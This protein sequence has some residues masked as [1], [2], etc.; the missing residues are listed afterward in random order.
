MTPPSA[1]VERAAVLR[2]DVY[3]GSVHCAGDR[4]A[5]GAP[6]PQLTKEV[7]VG[8]PIR[9]EVPAGHHAL[10]L[11]AFADGAATELLGS[12]CIEA[13]LAADTTPCFNLTLQAAPDLGTC[14]DTA[15]AISNCGACGRACSSTKVAA[16]ACVAGLCAPS[17]DPGYGDCNR[18]IAPAAD[19]GCETSLNDVNHC[20][21][22]DKVCQIP[23][24]ISSCPN[25]SCLLKSCAP[26]FFDCNGNAEDG[27]E[28][29]GTNLG[30]GNKGCCRG[31][32]QVQHANGIGSSF[33]DC[34]P[35]GAYSLQLA[36]DAAGPYYPNG[37]TVTTPLITCADGKTLMYCKRGAVGSV[38][39]ECA[40]WTYGCIG[41][42]GVC[43][44][45]GYANKISGPTDCTCPTI[46]D[47]P[48]Q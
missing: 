35:L 15:S 23:N 48:Y 16:P 5:P 10:V 24:A 43:P 17:C 4:I 8:Q 20:G 22:C 11:S 39:T 3:D 6:P 14:G 25:G 42:A 27:C 45:I 37:T 26:N 9:L 12:A 32:C 7:A 36:K 46:T 28:C 1:L 21:G 40:C 31:A 44:A 33:Y 38:A 19:D 30:D 47:K 13:D 41:D 34:L 2:L 29:P 18:P